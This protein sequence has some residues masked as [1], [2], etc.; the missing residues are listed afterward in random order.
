MATKAGEVE[1]R[2]GDQYSAALN[3]G[4]DIRH[5]LARTAPG[6]WWHQ[7]RSAGGW[8]HRRTGSKGSIGPLHN[9]RRQHP[10][11]GGTP[12][13]EVEVIPSLHKH[14]LVTAAIG[15]HKWLHCFGIGGHDPV[16]GSAH[17]QHARLE[18]PS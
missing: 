3:A 6:T 7:Q 2:H 14:Q 5:R 17:K 16:V 1:A 10:A 13:P 18:L 12:R 9:Q 4:G 8:L 11:I 15:T